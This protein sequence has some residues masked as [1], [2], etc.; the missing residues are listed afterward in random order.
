MIR[1]KTTQTVYT[2]TFTCA[3][4]WLCPQTGVP[5]PAERSHRPRGVLQGACCHRLRHTACGAAVTHLMHPVQVTTK[6][7]CEGEPTEAWSDPEHRSD[8]H[9]D[10]RQWNSDIRHLDTGGE[11]LIPMKSHTTTQVWLPVWTQTECE[12][13]VLWMVLCWVKE[14]FTISWIT[15]MMSLSMKRSRFECL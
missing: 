2:C 15:W 8:F 11:K 13:N 10:V 3:H 12:G 5:D 9:L 7:L 14:Q 4:L 1:D 6:H